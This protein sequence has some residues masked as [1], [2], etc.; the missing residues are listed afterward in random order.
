MVKWLI[1]KMR[2]V[3]YGFMYISF[4][5][6]ERKQTHKLSYCANNRMFFGLEIIKRFMMSPESLAM[7]KQ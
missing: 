2:K 3:H 4:Y 7:Y 1:D 5:E 6:K